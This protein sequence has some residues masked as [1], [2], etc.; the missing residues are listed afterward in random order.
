MKH[1]YTL[2]FTFALLATNYSFA[3]DISEIK[4]DSIVKIENT[5]L[6]LIYYKKTTA[7][8]HNFANFYIVEPTKNWFV[9]LNSAKLLVEVDYKH[10]TFYAII[11]DELTGGYKRFM[12]GKNR[13]YLDVLTMREEY[14]I[15]DLIKIDTQYFD[16]SF[17]KIEAEH[18]QEPYGTSG[19]KFHKNHILVTDNQKNFDNSSPLESMQF[20]GED[21][22]KSDG[23]LAHKDDDFVYSISKSGVYNFKK[24]EWILPRKFNTIEQSKSELITNPSPTNLKSL[25]SQVWRKKFCKWQLKSPAYSSIE[26]V[27]AVYICT[28]Q[29]DEHGQFSYIILNKDLK[30]IEINDFYNFDLVESSENGI[31]ITPILSQTNTTFLLDLNGKLRKSS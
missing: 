26:K 25:N 12:I 24:R 16:Q 4:K 18:T 30:P 22:I 9:Y 11:E 14:F 6:S 2:F 13:I 28:T 20:P 10:K 19:L 21:S 1:L 3:V 23:N 5:D 29:I 17:N 8:W 7:V 31:K 15:K 27:G